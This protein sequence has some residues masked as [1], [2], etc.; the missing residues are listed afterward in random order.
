MS[1]I[2]RPSALALSIMTGAAL[3]LAYVVWVGGDFM[4][5]R[6]LGLPFLGSVIVLVHSWGRHPRLVAVLLIVGVLA[7]LSSGRSPLRPGSLELGKQVEAV[8]S[9]RF[10]FA[11][12][13]LYYGDQWVADRP[14][15]RSFPSISVEPVVGEPVVR[16]SHY[17]EEGYR[18]GPSFHAVQCYG[19]SDPLIARMPTNSSGLRAGHAGRITPK[20]YI[21]TLTTG[22]EGSSGDGRRARF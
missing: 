19:L 5:G 15:L 9:D 18:W 21:E 10:M 16:M 12:E 20:V 22:A 6:F 11:D 3:Y 17:G 1:T 7:S 14:N 4:I 8:V 2:R 13:R